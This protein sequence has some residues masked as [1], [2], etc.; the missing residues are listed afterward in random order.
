MNNPRTITVTGNAEY[1]ASFAQNPILTYTI[2][3]YCDENQGFILGAGTYIAGSTASIAAIPTDGYMFVKW[4]DDTTDNPKELIVDHDIVLSAFFN[5]TGI[6]E[7][8]IGLI[9]LYPN[10]ANDRIRIEGLEIE[11]KVQIYNVFGI[12]V[13][14]LNINGDVEIGIDELS[15][16][17]YI[18]RIGGHAMKFM[19][20]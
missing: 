10:P 13:K 11:S 17:L 8:G 2:T 20:N 15:P 19:K 14:T 6:D 16:G 7:N 4:S 5:H 9:K 18:I 1:I 12:L 3:V